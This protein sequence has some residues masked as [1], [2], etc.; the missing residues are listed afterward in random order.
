MK[1]FSKIEKYNH[2]LFAE[3][4]KDN[5]L[6]NDI[7]MDWMQINCTDVDQSQKQLW[8]QTVSEILQLYSEDGSEMFQLQEILHYAT[9]EDVLSNRVGLNRDCQ[10]TE[11]L[12]LASDYNMECDQIAR[13]QSP[14]ETFHGDVRSVICPKCHGSNTTTVSIQTRSS[15]EPTGEQ[16]FCPCKHSWTTM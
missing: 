15:D 16:I 13:L 9:R 5:T 3:S 6:P 7:I 2:L 12:F 1:Q 8:I 10:H 4:M 11:A 14:E